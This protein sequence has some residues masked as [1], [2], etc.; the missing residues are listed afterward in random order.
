MH[1][2][3]AL[4][5]FWCCAALPRW[6]RAASAVYLALTVLATLGFGE[7]YAVDLVVAVPYALALAALCGRRRDWGMA[8]VGIALTL[9]WMAALRF[10]T[11][12]FGSAAFTWG[13]TV[14]TLAACTRGV[15]RLRSVRS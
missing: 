14:G 4:L 11:G 8:A 5:I 6:V 13:L 15:V 7:H 1:L 12:W 2:A 9:A 10:A 3:C